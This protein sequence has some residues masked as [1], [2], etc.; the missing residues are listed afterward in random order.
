MWVSSIYQICVFVTNYCISWC[1]SLLLVR[2]Y[3]FLFV[4]P[5]FWWDLHTLFEYVFFNWKQYLTL[6]MSLFCTVLACVFKTGCSIYL[7]WITYSILQFVLSVF[8]AW[9]SLSDFVKTFSSC[10]SSKP[11]IVFPSF[12]HSSILSNRKWY[13]IFSVMY[14]LYISETGNTFHV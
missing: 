8:E 10:V 9:E 6:L 12:Y 13:L 3:V 5:F 2:F 7:L 4:K 1:V 11:D 14:V